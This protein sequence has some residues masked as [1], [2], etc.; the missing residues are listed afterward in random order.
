MSTRSDGH[1]P[2]ALFMFVTCGVP[3]IRPSMTHHEDHCDKIADD[4][5]WSLVH[6]RIIDMGATHR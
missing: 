4:R 5:G 6:Q 1:N 3:L 2:P